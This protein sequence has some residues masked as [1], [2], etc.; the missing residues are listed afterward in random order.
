MTARPRSVLALVL[1]ASALAAVSCG[2][3]ADR[4]Q[5]G[6]SPESA[7]VPGAREAS[8]PPGD[9]GA[10][11]GQPAPPAGGAPGAAPGAAPGQAPAGD[12]IPLPIQIGEK[13]IV[14]R[15]NGKE[16][17]GQDLDRAYISS[18]RQFLREGVALSNDVQQQVMT[19]LLQAM[20]GTELLRQA[21]VKEGM[22][23]DPASVEATFRKIASGAP[24]EEEFKKALEKEGLTQETLRAQ[25]SDR[26]LADLWV[27]KYVA[28]HQ[29]QVGVTEAE[30]KEFYDK[31]PKMFERQETVR[32]RHILRKFPPN[33]TEQQKK[34]E[35]QKIEEALAKLTAGEDF[36]KVASTYSSDVT[37][38][39]GG[40]LGYFPRGRM[41]PQFEDVAF[42]QKPGEVS[43]VV[44]TRFGYHIIRTEE[45]V[46]GGVIPFAQVS[47]PIIEQMGNERKQKAINAEVEK[48]RA[49][50]KVE[51][52]LIFPPDAEEKAAGGQPAKPAQPAAPPPQ[53]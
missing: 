8:A 33:A 38:S 14:A 4:P 34:V 16:I 50:A 48:L 43:G 12:K 40:D 49:K 17:T 28:A 21:A 25:I 23:V 19:E 20:V 11:A 35:R 6:A 42:S 47:K 9:T 44:E 52:L 46:P 51:F 45:K 1:I 3:K 26:M 10:A 32:A 22:K 39:K 37:A 18:W 24:S 53:G 15:I 5:D 2:S 36:A 7:A 30:A 27:A 29:K 41:V 13:T 31:N